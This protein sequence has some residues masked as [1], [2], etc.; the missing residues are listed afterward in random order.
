MVFIGLDLCIWLIAA[1]LYSTVFLVFNAHRYLIH[2]AFF[3]SA[4]TGL[5]TITVAFFVMEH[6]LQKR[7][8]AYFF[9]DGGL[10][11][12]PKTLRIRIRTRLVALLLACTLFPLLPFS[13][14]SGGRFTAL[15]TLL[16]FLKISVQ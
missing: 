12:I 1:M 6:V 3:M 9:P 13:T 14:D 2:R 7:V 8:G 16:R 15:M 5:I 4:N 11:A 10:S